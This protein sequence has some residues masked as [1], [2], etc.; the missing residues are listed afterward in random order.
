MFSFSSV[1]SSS[2]RS[3]SMRHL[4]RGALVLFCLALL[5]SGCPTEE[6]K[7]FVL[8]GVWKSPYDSYTITKTTVSYLMDNSGWGGLDSVLNGSIEKSVK[9]SDNA[10]V[11]IIIVTES[12]TGNTAEKY[13]G[14]YYSD[15]TKSSI[16]MGN[17]MDIN[18]D[19]V[20]KGTLAEAQSAFT[21]DNVGNHISMW[22]DYTK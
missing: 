22:G 6:D 2:Q 4:W 7:G 14:V 21:V 1:Q 15:G 18:Y 8:E 11:L 9:F 17:A 13:T 10:G 16:K 5:F 3:G 12:T 19:P 20:E